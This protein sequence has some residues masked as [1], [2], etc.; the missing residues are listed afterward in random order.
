MNFVT[1][2]ITVTALR[3]TRYHFCYRRYVQ[4]VTFFVTV[5]RSTR[6]LFCYRVIFNTFPFLL[7]LLPCYLHR[8]TIFVATVSFNTFL[9]LLSLLP[10]YLHRVTIFVAT[11]SFN[12]FPFYYYPISLVT[13]V[14]DTL[15]LSHGVDLRDQNPKVLDVNLY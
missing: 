9:F 2:A 8:V 6:Y 11:V 10:R 4:R 14:P 1:V 3:S 5:L 15:N 12:T 7:S 13:I